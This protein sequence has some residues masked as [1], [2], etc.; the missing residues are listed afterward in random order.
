MIFLAFVSFVFGAVFHRIIMS[1]KVYEIEEMACKVNEMLD[2][3]IEIKKVTDKSLSESQKFID[4]LIL[5]KY[6]EDLNDR[7]TRI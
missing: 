5:V 7:N 1:K 6:K 4:E 3:A 2:K